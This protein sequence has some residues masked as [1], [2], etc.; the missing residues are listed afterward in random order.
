MK[1]FTRCKDFRRNILNVQLQEHK[2]FLASIPERQVTQMFCDAPRFD[3]SYVDQWVIS[4]SSRTRQTPSRLL[5][6]LSCPSYR[7]VTLTCNPKLPFSRWTRTTP[8]S[9]TM[10][11]TLWRTRTI[12][13]ERSDISCRLQGYNQVRVVPERSHMTPWHRGAFIGTKA[14]KESGEFMRVVWACLG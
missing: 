1:S 3:S 13:S 6:A 4:A 2:G 9:G 14:L 12:T 11:A 8:S 5:V 10:S 7:I